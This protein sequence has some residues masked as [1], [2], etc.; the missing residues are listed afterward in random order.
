MNKTK[1]KKTKR[2]TFARD[3]RNYADRDYIG[4]R[5]LF[6]N[7]CK[8]QFLYMASLCIEKYLKSII[9]YHDVKYKKMAESGTHDLFGLLNKCRSDIN[10][11][12]LGDKNENFIESINGYHLIRY[13]DFPFCAKRRYLLDLDFVVWEL[14]FYAQSPKKTKRITKKVKEKYEKQKGTIRGNN[15][16]TAF[17]EKVLKNRN[18]KYKKQRDNLIWKNFYYGKN[19]KNHI[20]FKAGRWAK[21]NFLFAG[22]KKHQ[23]EVYESVKDLICFPEDIEKYFKKI[24]NKIENGE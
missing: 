24:K 7:D 11:F 6:R 5:I 8:D 4:A 1:Q 15:I 17:L 18:D 3:M 13:P 12:S 10:H 14:R 22:S 20:K 21:N 9:I 16:I 23:I 2:N 19:K